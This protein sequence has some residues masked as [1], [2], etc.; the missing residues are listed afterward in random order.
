[1][2][3]TLDVSREGATSSAGRLPL[4]LPVTISQSVPA[5]A[6]AQQSLPPLTPFSPFAHTP[7]KLSISRPDKPPLVDLSSGSALRLPSITRHGLLVEDASR[8]Q[9][10]PGSGTIGP[11]ARRVGKTHGDEEVES[12]ESSVTKVPNSM[13]I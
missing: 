12:G 8:S 10:I 13:L 5:L 2:S 4:P 6:D 11:E 1:M 3:S 7:P 9:L